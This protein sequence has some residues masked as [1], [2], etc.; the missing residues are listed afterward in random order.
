M[1]ALYKVVARRWAEGERKRERERCGGQRRKGAEEVLVL[2]RGCGR[3]AP[4]LGGRA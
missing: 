3:C 1:S 2:G 4:A